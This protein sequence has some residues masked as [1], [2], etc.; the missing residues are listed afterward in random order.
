M[1]SL[2]P[3]SLETPRLVLR[4]SFNDT[5]EELTIPAKEA[6]R[7]RTKRQTS[8]F[9]CSDILGLRVKDLGFRVQGV[10]LY[11]HY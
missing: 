8:S 2:G 4:A 6:Q 9:I 3:P 10:G 11:Y 5:K 7:S 1:V